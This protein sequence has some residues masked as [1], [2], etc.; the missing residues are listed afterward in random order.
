[1]FPDA[2]IAFYDH[3]PAHAAAAFYASG[4]ERALVLTLDSG[5]GWG[6]GSISLGK[7]A[8]MQSLTT[9]NFPDSPGFL[10]QPDHHHAGM[11][12][13]RRRTSHAMAEYC[14]GRDKE[15]SVRAHLR[16][17]LGRRVALAAW[18]VERR[19]RRK[20]CVSRNRC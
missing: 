12:R 4:F 11:A 18:M 19:A 5:G 6:T 17:A 1:M 9:A 7:G 20:K 10:Y 16:T 13:R 15:T 14:W 2:E 3:H 8:E